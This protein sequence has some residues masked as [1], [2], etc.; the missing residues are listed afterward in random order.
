MRLKRY[1]R[2]HSESDMSG[3][4]RLPGRCILNALKNKWVWFGAGLIIVDT[5]SRTSAGGSSRR[6]FSILR[7]TRRSL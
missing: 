2:S 3:N 1:G 6:C 5:G 7:W 4:L